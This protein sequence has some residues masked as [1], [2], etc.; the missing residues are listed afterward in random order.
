VQ[1]QPDELR[2]RVDALEGGRA[3]LANALRVEVADGMKVLF[4]KAAEGSKRDILAE[5]ETTDADIARVVEMQAVM[6][7]DLRDQVIELR[8]RVVETADLHDRVIELRD[9]V[10]EMADRIDEFADLRYHVAETAEGLS[11][12]STRVAAASA[13][14][15]RLKQEVRATSASPG[16]GG[17]GV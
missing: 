3:T 16:P 4:F 2:G 12:I 15:R 14:G 5:R 11:R 13:R 9:R 17:G 10:V 8:D 1:G 6:A 7:G